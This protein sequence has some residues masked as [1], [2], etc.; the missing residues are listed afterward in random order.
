MYF[1]TDKLA[2][3]KLHDRE[4]REARRSEVQASKQAN[5]ERRRTQLLELK[6]ER[7]LHE[8]K[9]AAKDKREVRIT[10]GAGFLR[11]KSA[12]HFTAW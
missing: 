12:C 1:R 5:A 6:A 2:Q 11:V 4:L 9:R 3:S 8:T 10:S 7:Q